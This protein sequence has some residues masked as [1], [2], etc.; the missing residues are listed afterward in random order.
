LNKKEDSLM[1]ANK[2]LAQEQST[3]NGLRQDKLSLQE[4]QKKLQQTLDDKTDKIK[5]MDEKIKN[6][7]AEC[8]QKNAAFSKL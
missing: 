5:T 2:K 3:V 6:L 1:N 8:G 4:N 7:T